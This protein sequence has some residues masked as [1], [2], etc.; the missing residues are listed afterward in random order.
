[1]KA[2]LFLVLLTVSFRSQA[3]SLSSYVNQE[4]KRVCND[5]ELKITPSELK[6]MLSSLER[7]EN[8]CQIFDIKMY[9]DVESSGFVTADG[10]NDGLLVLKLLNNSQTTLEAGVITMREKTLCGKQDGEIL[11]LAY[12]SRTDDGTGVTLQGSSELSRKVILKFEGNSLKWAAQTVVALERS[13]FIRMSHS[14]SY[15]QCGSLK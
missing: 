4:T 1:M 15:F 7:R 3:I 14:S 10:Y 6:S 8:G 9:E 5:S 11:T 2:L 12:E 13:S